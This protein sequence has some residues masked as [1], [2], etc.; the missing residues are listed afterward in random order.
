MA[1]FCDMI[2]RDAGGWRIVSGRNNAMKSTL[3]ILLHLSVPHCI[4]RLRVEDET[5][6]R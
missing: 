2:A 5:S 1:R 3:P 6:I 4:C